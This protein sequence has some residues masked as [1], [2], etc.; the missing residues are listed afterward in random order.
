MNLFYFSFAIR[1]PFYNP[2]TNIW[3]PFYQNET[4]ISENKTFEIVLY[5]YFFNLFECTID[6]KFT[7]HDHCGPSFELCV[8]GFGICLQV[9]DNRHWN[10]EENRWYRKDDPIEEYW[11]RK[12]DPIE[13]Y[14]Y[15]DE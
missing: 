8:L 6:L 12:D 2:N 13:E 10:I 7:G 3:K 1:N 15:H 14:K 9:F 5:K 4:L 11:Y